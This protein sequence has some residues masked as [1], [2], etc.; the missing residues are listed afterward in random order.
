MSVL[1]DVQNSTYPGKP[2]SWCRVLGSVGLLSTHT[3]YPLSDSG[4]QCS[5]VCPKTLYGHCFPLFLSVSTSMGTL[6]WQGYSFLCS[7]LP[8][9]SQMLSLFSVPDW[10]L[11]LLAYRLYT[12]VPRLVKFVDVLTNWYVR[13]NRRRLKV[14]PGC[15]SEEQE[16]WKWVQPN[17]VIFWRNFLILHCILTLFIAIWWIGTYKF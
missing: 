9:V 12:V 15:F 3:A 2:V 13:M 14:R 6:G 7:F 16:V 11:L 4:S 8:Q 5:C 10:L 17:A 1:V